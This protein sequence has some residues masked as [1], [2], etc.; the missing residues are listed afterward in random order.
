M[1]A[2]KN[3]ARQYP[4][5]ALGLRP[6][7]EP[8]GQLVD[9]LF[10]ASLGTEEGEPTR[11]RIVYHKEGIE[12][13]KRVNDAVPVGGGNKMRPAWEVIPFEASEGITEFSVEDIRKIAPAVDLPRAFVVVGV[14][15]DGHL[16]IQGVAYRLEYTFYKPDG[17]DDLVFL[18]TKKPG[19]L[20]LTYQ[21]RSATYE[22]GRWTQ[23]VLLDH[24]VL[25]ESSIVRAAIQ[26]MCMTLITEMANGPK[27]IVFE[28][29]RDL[30][31]KIATMPHGGLIAMSPTSLV[32]A[33][34]YQLSPGSRTIL[35]AKI[36]NY[37]EGCVY[38]GARLFEPPPVNDDEQIDMAIEHE[39]LRIAQESLE[40]I[41]AGIAQLA[42]VDK[43]LLIGPNL[44]VICAGFEINFAASA[45]ESVFEATT[46]EGDL[47]ARYPIERHGSKHGAAASFAH[48]NPGGLVFAVSHDGAVRCLH[49]PPS[50]EKVFLWQI[51][52]P[53]G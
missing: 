49:R 42:A 24:L 53:D 38:Q 23:G 13:L 20:T 51:L 22:D 46:V 16:V 35:S 40:L 47:S 37:A 45:Y 34:K 18:Y 27:D 52:M 30:V 17:E 2:M 4:R 39:T 12:Q 8:L 9:T 43:A 11:V 3:N 10:F 28:V 26:H 41:V 14:R 33:G 50:Q 48:Q 25:R 5:E 1:L 6:E 44:E 32:G 21:M 31:R 15:A 29:V 7:D 36:K 19:H